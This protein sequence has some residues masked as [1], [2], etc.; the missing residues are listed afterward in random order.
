MKILIT[1]GAG[2]IGSHTV[3]SLINEKNI[4]KILIIDNFEDGSKKNLKKVLKNKKIQIFKR[5]INNI[6]SIQKLFKNINSDFNISS[7]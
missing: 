1:G 6:K 2:F 3:E 4:K 5:D 7:W